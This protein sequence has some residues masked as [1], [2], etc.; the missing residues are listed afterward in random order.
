M[1]SRCRLCAEAKPLNEIECT[2]K[3]QQMNIRQMLLDCCRWTA[4][5][6]DEYE[7]LPKIVCKTCVG[8]LKQSWQFA[9]SVEN[10][11]NVAIDQGSLGDLNVLP[12]LDDGA[13]CVAFEFKMEE[14]HN[15]LNIP[16]TDN[17]LVK[18]EQSDADDNDAD[19]Q[20][21]RNSFSDVASQQH[22][23][24]DYDVSIDCKNV[25][26]SSFSSMIVGRKYKLMD[27][28]RKEECNEDGTIAIEAIQRLQLIDW[29]II[30]FR[31]YICQSIED[32]MSSLRQHMSDQHSDKEFKHFCI[33]C[34]KKFKGTKTT[35]LQCHVKRYHLPYLNYW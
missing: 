2:I 11:N 31:C 14:S 5:E 32:S 21:D 18:D 15:I 9:N 16:D 34:T 28:V 4:F 13:T 8:N 35:S 26:N 3:D 24:H 1:E 30:R 33:F 10:L 7:N 17:P 23:E 6:S 19:D 20:F 12:T 22:S 27:H 29:T 25:E